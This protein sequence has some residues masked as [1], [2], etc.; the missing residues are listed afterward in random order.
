[1]DLVFGGL[2]MLALYFLVFII[3]IFIL[4][5][6]NNPTVSYE[7]KASTPILTYD[8]HPETYIYNLKVF[9]L[10]ITE[11][12]TLG[13]T[14]YDGVLV[15]DEI[16]TY[17]P[18]S[19]KVILVAFFFSIIAGILKGV[20]DYRYRMS[21]LNFLGNGSTWLLQSIP[22]F[23]VILSIQ[24][25]ALAMIPS[26]RVFSNSTWYNFIFIGIIVAIYPALYIARITFAALVNEDGQQY[27]QVARSKG[28]KE[29]I[30]VYKHMLKNCMETILAHITPLMV[31][32]L[33]SLIMAEYLF[34]YEGIAYRMFFSL[35]IFTSIGGGQRSF[36]PAM[37][38]GAAVCFMGTVMFAQMVAFITRKSLGLDRSIAN[39]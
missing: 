4:A 5:F 37:I 7:G 34:A 20:F 14:R 12:R 22:D 13:V 19:A 30:I 18:R 26:L 39:E 10:S 32:I 16:K 24:W 8:F 23:F 1:M 35:E 9:Y 11:H 17:F 3:L 6:P 27:I 33:S 29:R 31:Y 36:E 38:L 15:E 2:K 25:L 28:L 21:K